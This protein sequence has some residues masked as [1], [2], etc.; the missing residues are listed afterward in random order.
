MMK[1]RAEGAKKS[2]GIKYFRAGGAVLSKGN[3]VDNIGPKVAKRGGAP[4]TRSAAR[5]AQPAAGLVGSHIIHWSGGAG[6]PSR[7]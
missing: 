6:N 5:Y 4:A 7:G 2:Q 1:I 3:I